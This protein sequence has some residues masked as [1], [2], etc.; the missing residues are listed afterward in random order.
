MAKRVIGALAGVL[1]LTLLLVSYRAQTFHYCAGTGD[2]PQA[3]VA[4]AAE[5]CGPDEEPLEWQR[6]G[7]PGKIKLA[8]KA[9]GRA[10]GGN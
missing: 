7:W 8:A 5:T 4:G 2:R 1:L 9:A 3:R 6:L 10:F